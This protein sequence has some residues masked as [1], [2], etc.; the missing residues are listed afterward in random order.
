MLVLGVEH[1]LQFFQSIV[2]L[3]EFGPSLFLVP[4]E[5]AGIV[6][7]SFAQVDFVSGFDKIAFHGRPSLLSS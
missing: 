4:F 5:V 3:K 7:I 6:G 2:E 1:L